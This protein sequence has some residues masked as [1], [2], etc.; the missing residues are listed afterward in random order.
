MPLQLS[1]EQQ[2]AYNALFG[3]DDFGEG[4]LL[5]DNDFGISDE[6]LEAYAKAFMDFVERSPNISP[7]EAEIIRQAAEEFVENPRGYTMVH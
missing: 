4:G 2:E 3:G 7:D 6:E 1:N 5:E